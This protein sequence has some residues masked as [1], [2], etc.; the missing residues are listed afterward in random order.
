MSPEL[1]LCSVFFSKLETDK[2]R[3][4]SISIENLSGIPQAF[5]VIFGYDRIVDEVEAY[6][7]RVIEAGIPMASINVMKL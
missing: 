3:A 1:L 2:W 5:N 4:S 6:T 7:E